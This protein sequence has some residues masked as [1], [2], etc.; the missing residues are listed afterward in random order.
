MLISIS[1]GGWVVLKCAA[2]APER[3]KK[4]VVVLIG[5]QEHLYHPSVAAARARRLIPGLVSADL[6][7]D[8]GHTLMQEQPARGG[9][10]SRP[11][12]SQ[13]S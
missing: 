9:S 1:G 2:Y 6:L 8:A 4:A 12:I 5:Q 10:G 11:R 13:H 3:V 7:A